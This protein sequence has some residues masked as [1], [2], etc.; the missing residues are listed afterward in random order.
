[1]AN[2]QSM[3]A[4]TQENSSILGSDFS[5]QPGGLA[6]V[7]RGEFP[8]PVKYIDP[9]KQIMSFSGDKQTVYTSL[10]KVANYNRDA[11][12][13]DVTTTDELKE[14]VNIAKDDTQAI[15]GWDEAVCISF[16]S[17]SMAHNNDLGIYLCNSNNL[18]EAVWL[19]SN[20]DSTFALCIKS[21]AEVELKWRKW[22][23]QEEEPDWEVESASWHEQKTYDQPIIDFFKQINTEGATTKQIKEMEAAR[24][25]FGSLLLALAKYPDSKELKATLDAFCDKQTFDIYDGVIVESGLVE[26]NNKQFKAAYEKAS[27]ITNDADRLDTL[28]RLAFVV[29]AT[30]Y[31][32]HNPSTTNDKPVQAMKAT[33]A[34]LQEERNKKGE[35]VSLDGYKKNNPTYEQGT[36]KAF[37]KAY[38]EINLSAAHQSYSRDRTTFNLLGKNVRSINRA[39]NINIHVPTNGYTKA[40]KN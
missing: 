23:E 12:L 24:Y 7:L 36:L 22:D 27:E 32:D 21:W 5:L 1:M 18:P 29:M 15:T 14:I 33:I 30:A 37:P 39:S 2:V 34:L 9:T 13:C 3:P 10:V 20:M 16:Q 38:M 25:L 4:K 31:A 40:L 6:K 19:N 11:S 35:K 28:S 17:Y 8:F 26:K